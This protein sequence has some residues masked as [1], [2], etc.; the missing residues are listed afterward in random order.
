MAET[1]YLR[2]LDDYHT[3]LLSVAHLTAHLLDTLVDNRFEDWQSSGAWLM[4]NKLVEL[5]E[6][7]PF[8]PPENRF[9]ADRKTADQ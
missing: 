1:D 7:L 5:A 2:R 3:E 9:I 8:P 4:K 6:K